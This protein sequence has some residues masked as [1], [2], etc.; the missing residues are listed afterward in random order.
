VSSLCYNTVRGKRIRFTKLDACGTP[1]AAL[2]AAQMAVTDGFIS[3]AY[4]PQFEDGTENMQKNADGAICSLDK[5][6]DVF[7]RY[8]VTISLCGIDPEI[9]SAITGL[10]LETDTNGN[11]VGY[12]VRSGVAA[13]NFALEL[14]SGVPGLACPLTNDIQS[15]TEGGAGLTSFTLTA[16]IPGY[17][18]A[19]TASIPA[20]ST[21]AAVQAA[22]EGLD[23]IDPGDVSVSGPAGASTGPWL[24]TFTGRLAGLDIPLMTA[25]PTGGTGT[26]T[27]ATVVN[28]GVASASNV[29]YG[30]FLLPML[31]NATVR[32]FTIE[33]APTQYQIQAWTLDGTGWQKGPYN[34]V[35]DGAAG[36]PSAL[37]TALNSRDH[38]LKRATYVAPPASA[39]GLQALPA[40]PTAG[41]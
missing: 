18:S 40:A 3:V 2:T 25:T 20:S 8:Q 23:G 24:V 35:N 29:P 17:A 32:D 21:A 39:C 37:R 15:L 33:N 5:S 41:V 10:P 26:L 30:Y 7:K 36:V 13:V 22:L 11:S 31:R 1:A 16:V 6:D 9:I 19:T 12:R 38:L 4:A 34:V 28:G 14:W 27:V